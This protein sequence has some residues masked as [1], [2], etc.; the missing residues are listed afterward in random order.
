MYSLVDVFCCYFYFLIASLHQ[1]VKSES[2]SSSF[3]NITRSESAS[4]VHVYQ[5][6]DCLNI[7][8]QGEA[9]NKN[10][11]ILIHD[12]LLACPVI[13]VFC[14]HELLSLKASVLVIQGFQSFIMSFVFVS[15]QSQGN[16]YMVPYY[17]LLHIALFSCILSAFLHLFI[18][19]VVTIFSLTTIRNKNS[20]CFAVLYMT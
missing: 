7:Y 13:L 15:V 14:L 11:V 8:V 5:S 18:I 16:I 10:Y 4:S 17:F 9:A 3:I 19:L 12:S 6:Y 1:T 2:G 20:Y